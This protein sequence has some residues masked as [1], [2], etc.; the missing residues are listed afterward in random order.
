MIQHRSPHSV[1]RPEEEDIYNMDKNVG[2]LD[3]HISEL[4]QHAN[5]VFPSCP[6]AIRGAFLAKV[7]FFKVT[8]P[9]PSPCGVDFANRVLAVQYRVRNL[10]TQST[11]EPLAAFAERQSKVM[12]ETANMRIDVGLINI[13]TTRLKVINHVYHAGSQSHP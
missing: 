4:E 6:F 3:H 12:I 11:L 1:Q 5:R 13:R 7:S 10:F 9:T 2:F 8:K